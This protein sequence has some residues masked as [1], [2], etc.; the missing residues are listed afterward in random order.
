MWKAVYAT[1]G[2]IVVGPLVGY[3]A[4]YCVCL[5]SY[6]GSNCMYKLIATAMGWFLGVPIGA[7][8]FCFLGFLLGA[9]RDRRAKENVTA[10]DEELKMLAERGG[11]VKV[12]VELT[13]YV[14]HDAIRGDLERAGFLET[15][16]RTLLEK[17]FSSGSV[18]WVT[19]TIN[20]ARIGEL[21][22]LSFVESVKGKV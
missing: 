21:A 14:D 11:I 16:E 10:S 17:V 3:F 15:D 7:V 5:I 1:L 8:T 18:K 4:A 6:A 19:G 12:R 13:S 22:A 20:A 9:A 2:G